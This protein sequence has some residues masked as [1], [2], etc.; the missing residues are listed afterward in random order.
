[1]V[2]RLRL[3]CHRL[4][5]HTSGKGTTGK[6]KR[7]NHRKQAKFHLRRTKE[8]CTEI[9]VPFEI[10]NVQRVM[11]RVGMKTLNYLLHVALPNSLKSANALPDPPILELPLARA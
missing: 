4:H 3:R 6:D 1:L 10:E 8:L 9:S 5:T 7:A 2:R 11:S